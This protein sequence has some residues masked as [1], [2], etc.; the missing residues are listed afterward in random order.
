MRVA[1]ERQF[2]MSVLALGDRSEERWRSSGSRRWLPGLFNKSQ[3][4]RRSSSATTLDEEE[5]DLPPPPFLGEDDH[6][7]TMRT[8]KPT[9]AAPAYGRQ[10]G[11]RPSQ[12]PVRPVRPRCVEPRRELAEAVMTPAAMPVP[13]QPQQAFLVERRGR[14]PG[15]ELSPSME[16][17]SSN[18]TW[19]AARQR[20]RGAGGSRTSIW[21]R[22]ATADNCPPACVRMFFAG[23]RSAGDPAGLKPRPRNRWRPWIGVPLRRIDG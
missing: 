13:R 15:A 22:S 1:T 19:K 16:A 6:G 9:R 7:R 11:R 23:R 17:G 5:H 8:A 12:N 4:D 10:V 3:H 2:L 14:D 21:K 18:L 20:A